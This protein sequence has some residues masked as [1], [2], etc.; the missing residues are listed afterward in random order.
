MGLAGGDWRLLVVGEFC[1]ELGR[2]LLVVGG[3][4]GVVLETFGGRGDSSR[5]PV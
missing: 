3:G 2:R 4:V 5:L 1:G